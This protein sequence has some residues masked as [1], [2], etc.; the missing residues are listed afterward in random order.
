MVYTIF[1]LRDACSRLE[2]AA[3]RLRELEL[4]CPSHLQVDF[5]LLRDLRIHGYPKDHP[6]RL[7]QGRF[8]INKK[9]SK[10]SSSKSSSSRTYVPDCWTVPDAAIKLL[11]AHFGPQMTK[12]PTRSQSGPGIT[13]GTTPPTSMP[14][15]QVEEFP[16]LPFP[17]S[18]S[19]GPN[20]PLELVGYPPCSSS[21][22]G[23]AEVGED[24]P[25]RG[26]ECL[27]SLSLLNL[28]SE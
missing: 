7:L 13:S 10:S 6:L 17:A 14:P 8:N 4:A 16:T 3:T 27:I 11:E 23:S 24:L 22:I 12:E 18:L 21:S 26:S 28:L 25:A 2:M 5:A 19:L 15:C 1:D 9:S 20:P